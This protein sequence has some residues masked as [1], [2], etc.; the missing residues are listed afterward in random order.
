MIQLTNKQKEILLKLGGPTSFEMIPSDVWDELLALGLISKRSDGKYDLTE[1][2]EH[3]YN[4][5][6]KRDK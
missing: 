2:G 5:L 6:K 4:R 3:T 1:N